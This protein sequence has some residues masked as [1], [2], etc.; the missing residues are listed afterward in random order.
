[1]VGDLPSAHMVD[2]KLISMIICIPLFIG[3]VIKCLCLRKI[4]ISDDPNV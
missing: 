3:I 4:R 1:M 2:P